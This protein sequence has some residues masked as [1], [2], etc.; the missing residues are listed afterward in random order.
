MRLDGVVFLDKPRGISS[1]A[2]LQRVRRAYGA[3]HAGH[4]GTL[5]PLASGLLPI[6]FGDAAKFGNALLDADK[7]YVADLLLGVT[8]ATGDAEGEVLAVTPVPAFDG[9]A[10]EGCLA[11]LRGPIRQTPPMYS[12]LKHQGEPLY[13]YARRGES[14]ER[15]PRLITVHELELAD[16]RG[17]ELTLRIRCSKGTYVRTLAEDL[18]V[19][20][21]CGAHLRG[22]RRVA[23]GSF[24]LAASVELHRVEEAS[25][26]ERAAWIYPPDT[27]LAGMPR[28][29]LD[30]L[31]S[32]RLQQ[33]QA[34]EDEMPQ[35]FPASTVRAYGPGGQFLG[36]A[37]RRA[38][39][40]RA[41]R[42]VRM[43]RAAHGGAPRPD[44]GSL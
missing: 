1:N 17:A 38:G 16:R 9:E 5:D 23:V 12:A 3:D 8:T 7:E 10:L 4:T 35:E 43:D 30:A 11:R 15:P 42:L 34:V 44:G 24:G 20:L 13:R 40:L 22:L 19:L 14:V 33:G 21:G 36:I 39:C 37:D 27:L 2:A 29:E 41:R 18:G 25:A 6:V 26:A 28:V 32:A 31:Q